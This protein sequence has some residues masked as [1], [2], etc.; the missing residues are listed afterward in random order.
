MRSMKFISSSWLPFL[1]TLLCAC[2]GGR[3]TENDSELPDTQMKAV[4]SVQEPHILFVNVEVRKDSL[5][6]E[7]SAR[8]HSL[9]LVD[10]KL[11]KHRNDED[12][13][14]GRSQLVCSFLDGQHQLLQRMV[15]EHPLQRRFESV[16]EDGALRSTTVEL[17][18]G[19]LAL[20][21][22]WDSRIRY[23][24]VESVQGSGQPLEI[25]VL[26]IQPTAHK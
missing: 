21:T 12:L 20:R 9:M 13:H 14:K 17:Y 26:A 23:L 22:Q 8:L 10:G 24:R 4:G 11:K 18:E 16:D 3:T 25:A 7:E 19:Q 6:G 2:S 5:R 1:L 15:V